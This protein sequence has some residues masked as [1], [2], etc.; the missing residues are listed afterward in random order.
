MSGE[1]GEWRDEVMRFFCV[2]IGLPLAGN[3]D[4]KAKLLVWRNGISLED[5]GN[6]LGLR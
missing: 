4:W 5:Y 2:A 6:S 3:A 1:R